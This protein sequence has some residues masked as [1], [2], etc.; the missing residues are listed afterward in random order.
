LSI[1]VVAMGIQTVLPPIQPGQGRKGTGVRNEKKYSLL[2]CRR[3][4]IANSTSH[5]FRIGLNHDPGQ[6]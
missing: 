1:G 2:H 5:P 6:Q 4:S 3:K